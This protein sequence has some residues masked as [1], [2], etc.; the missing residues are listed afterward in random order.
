MEKELSSEAMSCLK[1]AKKYAHQ[2]IAAL[3]MTQWTKSWQVQGQDR[4]VHGLVQPCLQL[5]IRRERYM[6]HTGHLV[7]HKL[8]MPCCAC[9]SSLEV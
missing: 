1:E 3:F 2:F 4:A 6:F 5:E 7:Y 9:S 8:A